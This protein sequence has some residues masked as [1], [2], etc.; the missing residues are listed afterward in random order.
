MTEQQTF[1][2]KKFLFTNAWNIL[3]AVFLG[4]YIYSTTGTTNAF[5][6]KISAKDIHEIKDDVSSINNRIKNDLATKEELN[7]IREAVNSNNEEIREIKLDYVQV[8]TQIKTI[9]EAQSKDIKEIEGTLRKQEERTIEF[10]KTYE[11][12]KRDN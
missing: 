6:A 7:L 2:L 4:I 8:I 11:L 5:N 1:S 3:V 9:L 10:Y 12:K